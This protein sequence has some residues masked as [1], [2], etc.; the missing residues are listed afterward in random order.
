MQDWL[1]LAYYRVRKVEYALLVATF[2][3]IM[4]LGLELGIAAGIVA[5]SLIFAY[6]YSKARCTA[7][8]DVTCHMHT[9]VK[10]YMLSLLT[11]SSATLSSSTETTAAYTC[12]MFLANDFTECMVS[13]AQLTYCWLPTTAS[14]PYMYTALC[15]DKLSFNACEALHSLQASRLAAVLLLL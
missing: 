3:A 5:A 13:W 1:L 15:V 14:Q 9:A 7:V 12:S 2:V 10:A 11:V 6:Q 8:V 4:V